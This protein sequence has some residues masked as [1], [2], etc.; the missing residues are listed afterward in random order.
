MGVLLVGLVVVQLANTLLNQEERR[1]LL[2]RNSGIQFA[3]RIADTVLLLDALN[4]PERQRIMALLN[5]P[6]LMVQ[7][8]SAPVLADAAAASGAQAVLW[9]AVLQ[10]ILGADRPMQVTQRATTAPRNPRGPGT[11]YGRRRAQLEGV[12]FV[13]GMY[14]FAHNDSEGVSLQVQVR[15]RDGAWV[16]FATDVAPTPFSVSLSIVLRL[17][18]LFLVVL[19]LSLV[20]V[21]WMTRPLHQ[22]AC[23]ADALGQDIHHPPLP[24]TGSAEVR[25]AARAFNTMQTRLVRLIQDRTRMLAALSHDLK[26]P[27]TRLR[28]RVD[29]LDDDESRQRFEQDL[30]DMETMVNQT[31]DFMRGV[32]DTQAR[33]PIN[34]MALLETLQA[35]YAEMGQTVCITG[36]AP[37]PFVGVLSLLKRCLVNVLN[38]AIAYGQQADMAVEDSRDCLILRIRDHGPGIA[39]IEQ[40][41]VFEPFYRLE[42]SRNRGTGG[43][44]VG[45]TIVRSI[46]QIHG[47]TVALRNHPQG[48]LE[49]TLR[50]PRKVPD[51]VR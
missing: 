33:Q 49:V 15:L 26:T 36:E 29:L 19:V 23:A 42:S 40:E 5:T 32:D 44:G 48:G 20:A 7:L 25:Q 6:P 45:L 34:I 30:I 3:E 11:G 38:N 24:E 27:I 21:R 14:R 2:F 31:L 37:Q 9:Q 13:P 16:R 17:A 41:K 4:A 39:A 46:M 10:K 43:T 47:G 22:L 50:L 12:E 18:V 1:Q 51:V 8:S 28:L 35:D